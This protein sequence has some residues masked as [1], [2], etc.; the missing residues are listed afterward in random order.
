MGSISDN[1]RNRRLA[2]GQTKAGLARILGTSDKQIGRWEDGTAPPSEALVN[3]AQALNFSVAELLGIAPIGLDLSGEWYATWDTSRDGLPTLN[4]HGLTAT[5]AGEFV[6]LDADGDYDWRADLRLSDSKLTGTYQAV[7]DQRQ[8]RG[9][10]YFVLNHEGDAA[11]GRWTGQ[12]TDGILGG[13]FGA[14]ARDADR[15]DRLI[16]WLMEHDGPITEFP[17]EA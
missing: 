3:I 5:H 17:R 2:I 10:L 14:M 1:M 9:A 11:I 12:W 4:R 8:E 6:Y 15:A 13:G 7:S 16:K